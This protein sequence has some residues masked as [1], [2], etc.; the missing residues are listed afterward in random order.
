MQ[1][2]L[3]DVQE[4]QASHTFGKLEEGE[5]AFIV[6]VTDADCQDTACSD[7]GNNATFA[8]MQGHEIARGCDEATVTSTEVTNDQVEFERLHVAIEPR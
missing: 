7:V 6:V 2:V 3:A 1:L 8:D 4:P 5:R